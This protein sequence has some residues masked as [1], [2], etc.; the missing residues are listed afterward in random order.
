MHATHQ[1]TV[2]PTRGTAEEQ[3]AQIQASSR[4]IALND[5][6]EHEQPTA[7]DQIEDVSSS[8]TEEQAPP[9][10]VDTA[11][12]TSTSSFE[13]VHHNDNTQTISHMPRTSDQHLQAPINPQN[14]QDIWS[15]DDEENITAI[16]K[17]M[18]TRNVKAQ[19]HTN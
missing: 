7:P 8:S 6:H 5:I 18:S 12:T 16:N 2:L 13:I 10:Q 1:N 9:A 17:G 15:D 14:I 3:F 4:Q 11:V 19:I